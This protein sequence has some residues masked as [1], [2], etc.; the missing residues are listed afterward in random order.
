M[1]LKQVYEI[2]EQPPFGVVPELM[3]AQVVRAARFGEP[4]DAIR[5]EVVP[6]PPIGP[7]D[8]LVYV[9]SAGINYNNIWA[10]L[11]VPLDVIEFHKRDGDPSD[12]HI[13]GTDGAGIVWAVGSEVTSVRPGQEIV[14]YP[15]AWDENDPFVVN[16]GDPIVAPSGRPLGYLSSWGTFAQFARLK[17]CQCLPRPQ[18]LT[19]EESAAYMVSGATAYRM[20]TGFAEHTVRENDVVLVWGAA[21]GVGCMA[22][23][24]AT[25]AGAIA[26]A[27]VSS[28]QRGRYCL[29]QGCR[30]YID[31]RK[32]RHWG[33]LPHWT[34][35]NRYQEWLEGARQFGSEIW[36]IV[37]ARRN[38]RIVIEHPGEATLPTSLYVCDTSGMVAICGG[39][40]GYHASFDLRH[41]WTRQK[42]VQGAQLGDRREGAK[43]NEL[44]SARRLDPCVGK[45]FRFDETAL[46][47]QLLRE[48]RDCFGNSVVRV[49]CASRE[50]A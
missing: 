18:H 22:V 3:F 17:E 21:G 1:P 49:G 50:R 9:M 46:A 44:V 31:R 24:I 34:D 41:H 16:G 29:E 37:G 14:V 4:R 47:H 7:R 32:F 43:V 35:T 15:H 10:S 27:V 19:W 26:V 2:G 12:F 5:M 28:E 25:M 40:S 39:T 11:G 23:Q 8:V 42:R 20:L 6:V 45:T 36:N 30:G 33:P 13:G 38:P 48:S